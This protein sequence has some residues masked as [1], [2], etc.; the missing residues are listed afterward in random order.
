MNQHFTQ[1]LTIILLLLC[2]STVYAGDVGVDLNIHL[3]D[4]PRPVIVREPRHQPAPMFRVEDNTEFILPGPLG[5]FVAVGVPYD[6]FFTQNKYYLFFDG[7]WHRALHRHGPWVI[8]S[9][10]DLPPGLRKHKLERIRQYRDEEY[11]M[12]SRDKEHYP[13]KHFRSGNEEWK[14]EKQE[15]KEDHGRHKGRKYRD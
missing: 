5:F 10:R 11:D 15:Q 4:R 6:L 12:Y 14:E 9:H 8:I 2:A 13:G 1:K 3:G 7:S